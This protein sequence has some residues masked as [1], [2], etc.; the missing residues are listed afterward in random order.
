MVDLNTSFALE[1]MNNSY[2]S[3]TERKKK[4]VKMG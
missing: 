1:Y 3:T 2:D 4:S